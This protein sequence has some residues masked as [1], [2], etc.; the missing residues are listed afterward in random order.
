M[1]KFTRI[2][3]LVTA[4]TSLFGALSAT[5]GAVTWHN[6]GNTA[7][8][9]HGGA[10]TLSSTGV[11]LTCV[12]STATGSAPASVVGTTYT[13]TKRATYD[14]CRLAGITSQMHC[15]FTATGTPFHL[16]TPR[17]TTNILHIDCVVNAQGIPVCKVEGQT[18][19]SYAN[20][21]GATAGRFSIPASNTV[22]T[23]NPASG[24]CPLGNGDTASLTAQ[25]HTVTN[26]TGGTGTLGPIINRTA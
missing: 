24:T 1:S 21:S 7:F 9:A 26:G 16:S 10:G 19:G 14:G 5:A 18:S 2:V 8:T 17:M 23:T 15:H 12:T 25:T 20:P 22:R 4:L 13:M 6:T 11:N 3:V